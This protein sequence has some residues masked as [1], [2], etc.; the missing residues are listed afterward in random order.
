MIHYH[1]NIMR[2]GKRVPLGPVS[3]ERPDGTPH[4]FTLCGLPLR[5]TNARGEWVGTLT[6]AS[7]M[8]RGSCLFHGTRDI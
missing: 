3:L 5:W 7:Q 8:A 4:A 1:T 2:K 6:S